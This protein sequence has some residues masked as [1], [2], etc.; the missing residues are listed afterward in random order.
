MNIIIMQRRRRR[1]GGRGRIPTPVFIGQDP[2]AKTF[3]AQPSSGDEDVTLELDELE[4][5]RLVDVESLTQEEAGARMGI[6]RGTVWRLLQSAR[7]KIAVA[8]SQGR[9]IRISDSHQE[10]DEG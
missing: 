10:T 2:R 3:E 8:L 9:T 5:L 4:A 6:S 7:K 1:R